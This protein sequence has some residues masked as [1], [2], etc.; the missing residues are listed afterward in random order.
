MYKLLLCWRYLRTRY[1]AMI[2]I[3]SVMLG[4]AT[5]IVVNSVMSGFSTKLKDRLHGVLSDVLI[6]CPSYEGFPMPPDEMIR[7]IKESPAG[8]YVA[9]VTPTV[10]IFA[11]VQFKFRGETMTKPVRL[12][13]IDPKTRKDVGGFA[14]Y[15]QNP[16]NRSSPSFALPPEAKARLAQRLEMRKIEE[17]QRKAMEPPKP[18]KPLESEDLPPPDPVPETPYEPTGVIVGNAIASYRNRNARADS[19]SKDTY[20]LQPGDELRIFTVGAQKLEPVF[21]TL[22]VS[23]YYKSEMSEYDGSY[24]FVPLDHLQKLRAMEG[25]VT[26]VQM[27]LTDPEQSKFVVETLKEL[28]PDHYA[29]FVQTWEDK[30]GPLLSAI[31]VERGILNVLLFMIVCVAGFSILAIFSMIVFEKTRD[32]GILK[33][34]GASHRGVM[35]IFLGYG[36]LLGVVGAVLGTGLGL[37]FTEHINEIE[38]TLTKLTGQELFPRDIY[39]FDAIPTNIQPLSVLIVDVGAILTAVIFSI[40]PA[41]RAALLHPVRALRFE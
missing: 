38:K 6:E 32:I 23:D 41:L 39:Y 13:G 35:T 16:Q 22:I 28:F 24:V 4:V 19:P 12:I 7:R 14:E 36:L 15:L 29:Y 25:R 37:W 18:V 40:L 26:S 11:M 33:S 1:L 3:G 9:A 5:L 10:E 30:Q 21:D 17:L 27:R 8:H 2:C 20:L 31:A 34:L